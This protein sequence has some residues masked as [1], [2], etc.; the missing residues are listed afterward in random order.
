MAK[1]GFGQTFARYHSL[2]DLWRGHNI[3]GSLRRCDRHD[4]QCN[5]SMSS[6]Y[7]GL[8]SLPKNPILSSFYSKNSKTGFWANLSPISQPKG[9]LERPANIL[10]PCTSYRH[11]KQCF[12]SRSSHSWVAFIYP[13]N[14]T[15]S[16]FHG[17]NGEIG[18][19]ANFSPI[20][21][22]NRPLE[23]PC[24]FIRP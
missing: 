7:L 24:N 22:P 3:F 10:R 16:S 14:P 1:L 15:L 23:R 8:L 18:F 6:H 4:I 11:N 12:A 13:K 17:K 20:L 2:K 21:Q 9:P 19:L 5:P